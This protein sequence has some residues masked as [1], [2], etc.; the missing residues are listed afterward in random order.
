MTIESE[1]LEHMRKQIKQTL[2]HLLHPSHDSQTLLLSQSRKEVITTTI[3]KMLKEG[4]T[5]LTHNPYYSSPVLLVKKKDMSWQFCVNYRAL[6]VVKSRINSQFHIPN[7][8]ELLINIFW[9]Y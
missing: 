6:Y 4:I 1:T 7:V 2:S 8:D 3:H 5:I 9:V